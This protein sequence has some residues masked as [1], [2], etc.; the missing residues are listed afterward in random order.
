MF[1]KA[2]TTMTKPT[3]KMIEAGL[4]AFSAFDRRFDGEEETVEAIFKAMV[5]VFYTESDN[6]SRIS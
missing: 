2:V 1:V 5:A 3:P 6:G 4:R